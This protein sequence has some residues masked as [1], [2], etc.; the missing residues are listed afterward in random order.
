MDFADINTLR[1]LTTVAGFAAYVGIL[2][3]A[4]ARGNRAAFE[5]AGRIPFTHEAD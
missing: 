1:I 5:D 2:R 4:Y 3:W